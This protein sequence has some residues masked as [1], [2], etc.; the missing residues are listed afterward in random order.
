MSISTATPEQ[1]QRVYNFVAMLRANTIHF[2]KQS[3]TATILI[4]NWN[5]DIL[6][7]IGSPT[8]IVI[9]DPTGLA[10]A[11]PL[12]DTQVTNL[13]GQHQTLQGTIMTANNQN[14]FMLA[15]G[16]NNALLT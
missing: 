14:L 4:Q 10:G 2:W 6:Q 8:G 11:V 15:T 12:T 3:N 5:S 16:P 9:N 1:L 7:I 13:F